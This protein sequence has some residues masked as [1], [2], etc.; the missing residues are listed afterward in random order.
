MWYECANQTDAYIFQVTAGAAGAAGVTTAPV[1]PVDGPSQ[2]LVS[3]S[4]SFTYHGF[5][6]ME[7]SAAEVLA[8]GTERTLTQEL[9]GGFPFGATCV[10]F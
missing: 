3:Y 7:L 8:D 4:P 1:S 9:Q 5:R 10:H 6:F 2:G